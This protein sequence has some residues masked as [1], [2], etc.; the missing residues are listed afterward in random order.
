MSER[1][2]LDINPN[3]D[4]SPK[5][6][7]GIDALY[8]YVKVD[9]DNY[10]TFYNNILLKGVLE[11]DENLNLIS[12]DYSKQ[13]TFFTYNINIES[14]GLCP[15]IRPI[16]KIG[17]KNLNTKD[18]LDSILIQLDSSMMNLLGY[19][20]AVDISLSYLREITLEPITT[21][22]SRVDLNT[23]CKGYNFETLTPELFATKAR[24]SGTIQP[25]SNNGVLETFYMGARSSDSV[26]MRIYNKSKEL[27]A[28]SSTNYSSSIFK[29]LLIES[30]F[31]AKYGEKTSINDNLWNVEFEVK[32]GTLRRY[33]IHTLYDLFENI[34]S[35]HNDIVTGTY[36]MLKRTKDEINNSRIETADI[37]KGI[38]DNFKIFHKPTIIDK[39][40]L[41]VYKKDT[42]WLKNRMIEFIEEPKNIDSPMLE[43]IKA[44]LSKYS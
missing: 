42:Q 31:K 39:E 17:F 41:K 14:E 5:F 22:V 35:L 40:K 21:K 20:K 23:Y 24:K 4:S 8:F 6:I 7:P 9:Y 13:W 43:D 36:R 25:I 38:T 19:K 32:R 10:I 2:K 33:K 11:N 3:E 18:N 30:K 37:W 44:L 28:L 12:Y 29:S 27:A 1:K 26:F 16:F 15:D 34:D